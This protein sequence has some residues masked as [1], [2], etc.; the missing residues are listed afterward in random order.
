MDLYEKYHVEPGD[1]RRGLFRIL[2]EEF[3][4]VVG[5]YP[6]CYVH[7]TPSFYLPTVIYV[8]TAPRARHFFRSGAALRVIDEQKTFPGP[9]T[10][11]FHPQ[12]YRLPLPVEDGTVDLLVSQYAGFVSD[13]CS[14]YL[15]AG[16]LLVVN[17]SHGDAGLASVDPAFELVGV[18]L[19]DDDHFRLSTDRLGD[20]FVRTSAAPLPD[21][22]DIR[23]YLKGLD[24]P[25]SYRKAADD[26]LFRKR[27]D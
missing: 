6:G 22:R 3:R 21:R 16:G 10:V 26:Y 4:C 24:H 20:Y 25:L 11:R 17:N 2:R 1:E 23:D 7:V 13:A 8:D 12:D 9:A 19:R 27:H 5:L 15:R 18:F 14:R